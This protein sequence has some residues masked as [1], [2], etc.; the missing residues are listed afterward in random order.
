MSAGMQSRRYESK[1]FPLPE[2]SLSAFMFSILQ[3][4]V[5]AFQRCRLCS[6]IRNGTSASKNFSSLQISNLKCQW[7]RVYEDVI[8]AVEGVDAR[9]IVCS[10]WIILTY[11]NLH[12]VEMTNVGRKFAFELQQHE[13]R[14][15]DEDPTL[16]VVQKPVLNYKVSGWKFRSY[17]V[18]V[19]HDLKR[20]SLV[21]Y[22]RT[23]RI[24]LELAL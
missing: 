1:Y 7:E 4:R 2:C 3:D 17:R 18:L 23:R 14:G 22:C 6:Q 20:A 9:N 19:V 24:S 8:F 13:F 11:N 16:I 12:I 5:N 21:T 15:S 10:L